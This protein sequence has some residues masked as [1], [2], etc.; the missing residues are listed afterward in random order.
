MYTHTC[1]PP[2]VDLSLGI[3]QQHKTLNMPVFRSGHERSSAKSVTILKARARL[4]EQSHVPRIAC[5]YVR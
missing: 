5:M 4:Q 2:T 1:R 3:H